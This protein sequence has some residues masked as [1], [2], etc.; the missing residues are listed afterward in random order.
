[1]AS[2]QFYSMFGKKKKE[3][4]TP[5]NGPTAERTP[6]RRKSGVKLP[7]SIVKEAEVKEGPVEDFEWKTERKPQKRKRMSVSKDEFDVL[8]ICGVSVKVPKG[9]KPYPTQKLMMVRI[10]MALKNKLNVLAESPTGSGKTMALLASTTAWLHNYYNER[11]EVQL[12][13][14]VHGMKQE[15]PSSLLVENVKKEEIYVKE[16][17]LEDSDQKTLAELEWENDFQVIRKMGIQEPVE[18][19]NGEDENLEKEPV[20]NPACICLPR[21]R[22]YYGT[23]THKQIAQVVAEFSRLPYAND[24][25]HTILASREQSCINP[26]ARKSF[27]ISQYCKDINSQDGIGCNF[28]V[29]MKPRFEKASMLRAHIRMNGSNVFDIEELVETLSISRPAL[30][31]YFCSTRVLTQDADLIFCPFSYLVDP[32]IRASSDV[33]VKNSIIILDEAHNIE[34]TCR[35]AAS[36]S[37]TEKEIDDCLTSLRT[38]Q[39]ELTG[40]IDIANSGFMSNSERENREKVDQYHEIRSNLILLENLMSHVSRW[41]RYMAE[42]AKTKPMG[43]DGKKTNTMSWADLL[44]SLTNIDQG[45][46]IFTPPDS[47]EYKEIIAAYGAATTHHEGDMIW[48]DQ[49]RP[50]GVAIVCIEKWLY[51]QDYF[52]REEYQTTYRMNICIEEQ[53]KL[54]GDYNGGGRQWSQRGAGPRNNKYTQETPLPMDSPLPGEKKNPWLEEDDDD[55]VWNDSRMS[56]AGEE[57]IAAGCKTT[58][59]LWCMSPALAFRGAFSDARSVILASGTLCPMDTLKTELGVEFKAQMEG[60]QVIPSERI[61]AAVLPTGPNGSRLQATYRNTS[62]IESPFY[63]EVGTLIRDVCL[64][65]PAGVLCFVPSYRLLDQLK[66]HMERKVWLRQIELKKVVLFEPRRSSE[67]GMVMDKFEEA[68]QN[69]RKFGSMIDGAL[70]FAVFRGKISE[71]IDFADDRARVVISVGIPFPNSVDEL[72]STKRKYNDENSKILGI[73][74]GEEWYVTQAYRALNQALGRCLRHKNDWGAL[75]LLDER[76]ERQ[77]SRNQLQGAASARVSKWIRAQLRVYPRFD[78]FNDD[79]LDFFNRMMSEKEEK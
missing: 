39:N 52:G 14:P 30:C 58:I 68:I 40:E 77:A 23:R 41:F 53:K 45:I 35:D 50:S 54:F 70:M 9:L 21:V 55:D 63:A 5:K 71:G 44:A 22:I 18:E 2:R 6:I 73:L 20:K 34:D 48:M 56:Q 42:T 51:F 65:V 13:C 79:F 47:K 74:N 15:L 28:K 3:A 11:R 17:I 43:R 72:V 32:I 38:K 37:F 12:K 4:K 33:H 69:P 8:P 49:Y 1:M 76:L 36:F 19:L 61:F 60:D 16:E 67:L 64:K 46:N 26:V 10:L 57:P 31:P 62:D 25:K 59:S 66:Q 29:A 75:I 24:I 7:E 27:D 78:Q